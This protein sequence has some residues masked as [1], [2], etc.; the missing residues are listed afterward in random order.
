[1]W[2]STIILLLFISTNLMGSVSPVT[3]QQFV[4]E[5]LK[6]N[7]EFASVQ[8]NW[9]S[10]QAQ[11]AQAGALPDPQLGLS[12]MNLPTN[13]FAFDQEP[14][15]GKKIALM[16]MFPFPGKLGLKTDIAEYQ[17]QVVEQQMSEFKNMLIQ[18]V[19]QTYYDLSLVDQSIKIIN[20]NK[21]L[22]EQFVSV[23][24]TK[25][26]G[27]KGLQQDV[28]KA[29]VELARIMEKL[30]TLRQKRSSIVFSMN[31]LLNRKI[32]TPIDSGKPVEQTTYNFT[33]DGLINQGLTNRPLLK[34]WQ[35]MIEK[36]K[37]A[38]K[39]ARKSYLP[40][41]SLGVA[42]A[43][44]DDLAGGMKS[45]DFF[46]AELKVNLPL[47]F[48]RKQTKKI[49]EIQYKLESAEE[50]YSA[51]KNEVLFQIEDAFNELSKNAELIELYQKSIIPQ[52]GQ[53]LNSAMSGYQVDKVDFLTLLNNQII[54]FNYELEYYR[55]LTE[56][57]KTFAKL[58]AVVGGKLES[59]F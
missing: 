8:K 54:L 23:V 42:Y 12:I 31:K 43:Q 52:A 33:L 26:S 15:T 34:S 30:I 16:Q 21:T 50:K 18:Q 46:S 44:R 9:Q 17:T 1:M 51:V 58:E 36:S 22:L 37:S 2:R 28:L 6:N 14:M 39:L 40:D 32:S 48:F 38:L 19:K 47:Y 20:R 25:Y 7:P 27:G 41:F 24:E 13:S 3:L 10:A 4:D 56:H 55:A 11:V 5:A 35:F 29:R 49:E 53:S 57:E 59:N 45:D